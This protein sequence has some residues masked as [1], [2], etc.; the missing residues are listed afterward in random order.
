MG[1][2]LNIKEVQYMRKLNK[3]YTSRSAFHVN[4]TMAEILHQDFFM[5]VKNKLKIKKLIDK[6]IFFRY[7]YN[8]NIYI[9]IGGKQ[10]V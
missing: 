1:M 6:N 5:Q 9:E 2:L 10:N 8:R 3:K 7:N 4:Y